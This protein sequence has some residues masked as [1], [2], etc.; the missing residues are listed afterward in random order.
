MMNWPEKI[1]LLRQKALIT[2]EELA[3]L[4]NVAFVSVNR[5][6]NGHCEPTM[7]AKRDLVKL[8]KKYNIKMED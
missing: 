3:A 6:E 1:K 4:I 8:F 2:Q 7:S 5:W